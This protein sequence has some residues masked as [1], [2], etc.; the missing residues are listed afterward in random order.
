MLTLF[1]DGEVLL[2]HE[3]QR[4]NLLTIGGKIEKV[5]SL[6]ETLLAAAGLEVDV[7]DCHGKRIIPGLIDPQIHLAGGSGEDGFL[8]QPP[9]I[10][11]Q[12][13]ISAGITTTVATIGVDTTT[14]TMSNLV[15]CVKAFKEAGLSSYAYT[16]GYEV[17]P[18]TITS[19][20]RDD[21]IYVEEIIGLGEVA[22][23]DHR[24]PEPSVDALAHAIVD[25]HVGGILT[26]KA[27]ISRIHVGSGRR[28]LRLIHE[29]MDR[30]E[31]AYEC[32]YFTHMDRTRELLNDGI[33]IA[34]RGS[35]VDLDVHERQLGV[36]Y[37]H[38]LDGN[39][40][41]DRLSFST[42]AG[43]CASYELWLEIRDCVLKHGFKLE[44]VL[45]HSTTVPA[46]ALRLVD[47]GHLSEGSDADLLVIDRDLEI[48]HV[49]ANGIFFRRD[50]HYITLE[51]P[52][53]SRRNSV[54]YGL[55]KSEETEKEKDDSRT[56]SPRRHSHH[57][58][59]P[60]GQD[61]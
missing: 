17:P 18:V 40:P 5:G 31:I 19:R 45:T 4:T 41:L 37:K 38:Y 49:M 35:F 26:K 12:D 11:I 39:G 47:K 53:T 50:G 58:R 9:R 48:H 10:S 25:A 59:G 3:F 56:H 6:S 44:N 23:A 28:R 34:R 61:G 27:G 46:R 30:H 13:C 8:S 21:M 43:L 29:M 2:R 14:K 1:K 51:Q 32:L 33:E 52:C 16:G 42:D 54:C 7:V 22:I 60:R 57:R 55:K 20:V 24:V 36:W 15:A